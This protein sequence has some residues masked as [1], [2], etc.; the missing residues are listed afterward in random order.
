[1]SRRYFVGHPERA[2]AAVRS[3]LE[4][5]GTT[6]EL[7]MEMMPDLGHL[8]SLKSDIRRTKSSGIT[9]RAAASM[10]VVE[11][12]RRTDRDSRQIAPVRREKRKSFVSLHLANSFSLSQPLHLSKGRKMK[13]KSP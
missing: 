5:K 6:D 2:S 9:L 13:K 11:Q 1:M 8:V 12:K 3:S 4:K 7:P 10:A